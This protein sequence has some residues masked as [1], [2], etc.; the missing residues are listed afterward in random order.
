MQ[1]TFWLAVTAR[2][3]VIGGDLELARRAAN[4][5]AEHDYSGSLPR[6]WA[7]WVARMQ[8]GAAD[9]ALAPDLASAAQS[10]AALSLTCGNC[11][12]EKRR[13]PKLHDEAALA[14][15]DPPEDLRE[16]MD[17]HGLGA[18]QLWHGLIQPSEE[19]WLNGTVTLTRAPLQPALRA[20]ERIS[21]AMQAQVEQIRALAQRARAAK[22][23][24]ERASAYGEVI[25]AC[26]AC[27]YATREEEGP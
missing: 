8:Q 23:H 10:V 13:A 19:M 17:R 12:A 18:E 7:H 25:A 16:R 2:D 21:P 26:S 27:H 9:V 22:S 11:H 24:P 15:K 6:D 5:L 1:A 20:G 3:G 14:W 4:A